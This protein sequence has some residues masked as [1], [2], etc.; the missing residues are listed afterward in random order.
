MMENDGNVSVP[1]LYTHLSFLKIQKKLKHGVIAKS[2]YHIYLLIFRSSRPEV[3]RK[4]GVLKHLTKFTGKD[5][6][7][8]LF[9]N[10]VAGLATES[11]TQVFSC[12][13]REISEHHFYRTPPVSAFTF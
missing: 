10:K 13:F 1:P 5:L 11:L 4:K 2:D 9:L 3:F 7:Q 6:H 12:E 8:R